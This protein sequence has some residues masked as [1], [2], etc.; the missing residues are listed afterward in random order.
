M[1]AD[2]GW[3]TSDLGHGVHVVPLDDIVW[4]TPSPACA[5]APRIENQGTTCWCTGTL[6]VRQVVIHN[7]MD[8]RT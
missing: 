3:L 5:C 8:G 1:S 2:A 7:A 4:H 6:Y